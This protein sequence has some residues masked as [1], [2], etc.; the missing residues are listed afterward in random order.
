VKH[1][2]LKSVFAPPILDDKSMPNFYDKFVN[3]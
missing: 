3:C 2:N 1:K